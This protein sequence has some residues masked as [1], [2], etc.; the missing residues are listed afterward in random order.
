[1]VLGVGCCCSGAFCD[2]LALGRWILGF[3]YVCEGGKPW[4]RGG[5]L[6][7]MVRCVVSSLGVALCRTL[8]YSWFDAEVSAV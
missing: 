6:S 7:F 4:K 8:I 3:W 2:D 1:M 5:G